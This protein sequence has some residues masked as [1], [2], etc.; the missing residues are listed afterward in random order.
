[1][2]KETRCGKQPQ[3]AAERRGRFLAVGQHANAAVLA[4]AFVTSLD[5]TSNRSAQWV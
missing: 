3:E 4:Q 2:G 5:A 1:V